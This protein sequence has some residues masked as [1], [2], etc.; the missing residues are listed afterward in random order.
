MT[1]R[2]LL[3]K[4]FQQVFHWLGVK[5]KE[6]KEGTQ[7]GHIWKL[8]QLSQIQYHEIAIWHTLFLTRFAFERAF[9][10]M[11]INQIH[12][13]F[14]KDFSILNTWFS[15]LLNRVK[16]DALMDSTFIKNLT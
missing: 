10:R 4:D 15:D 2:G 9:A 8:L 16:V 13:Y 14:E 1:S 5:K 12:V 7:Q 6:K 3:E 11:N